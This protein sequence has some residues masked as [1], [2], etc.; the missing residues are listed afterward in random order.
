MRGN[1]RKGREDRTEKAR[2]TL[3]REVTDKDKGKK[4]C[5]PRG[6][7]PLVSKSHIPLTAPSPTNHS[8]CLTHPL[9]FLRI[10]SFTHSLLLLRT[11]LFL[12]SRLHIH[13]PTHSLIVLFIDAVILAFKQ[14]F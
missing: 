1:R 8:T 7:N 2:L 5:F 3:E 13:S 11:H 4:S 12:H 9:I 6:P 10:H 14:A